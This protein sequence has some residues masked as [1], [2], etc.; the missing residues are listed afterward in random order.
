MIHTRTIKKKDSSVS[1]AQNRERT[2]QH[3]T[4]TQTVRALGAP[5]L[6][7]Q[8]GAPKPVVI[9][10]EMHVLCI[11]TVLFCCCRLIA[12]LTTKLQRRSLLLYDVTHYKTM[13]LNTRSGMHR[14]VI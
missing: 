1:A 3:I 12:C 9:A 4:M 2:N 5:T 6:L 8:N 11:E 14:N 7:T 10:P 13:R